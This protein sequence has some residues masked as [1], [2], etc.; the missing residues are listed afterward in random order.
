MQ[1][2]G[3]MRVPRQDASEPVAGSAG[4]ELRGSGDRVEARVKTAEP[5]PEV[6]HLPRLLLDAVDEGIAAAPCLDDHRQTVVYAGRFDSRGC[7][8][9]GG[10]RLHGDALAPGGLLTTSEGKDA[11]R[12][13]AAVGRDEVPE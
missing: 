5:P 7:D 10:A 8:A 9:R 13:L 2:L 6:Q 11:Q 4:G 3:Q 1:A 12:V